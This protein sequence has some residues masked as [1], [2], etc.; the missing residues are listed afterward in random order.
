MRVRVNSIYRFNPAPIDGNSGIELGA[1]VRVVNLYGCPPA[2]TMGH[3]YV[4]PAT[5]AKGDNSN[6]VM[7][8]TGSLE[9]R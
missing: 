3:C 7:V 6:F 4:I 8:C 5:N 9:K 2:N 1:L